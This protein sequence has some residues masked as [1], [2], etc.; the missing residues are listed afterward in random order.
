MWVTGQL[1]LLLLLLLYISL[2]RIRYLSSQQCTKKMPELKLK[3]THAHDSNFIHARTEPIN[4]GFST[5][6]SVYR[7]NVI[8]ADRLCCIDVEPGARE[9]RAMPPKPGGVGEGA[10][11]TEHP[12]EAEGTRRALGADRFTPSAERR[13]PCSSCHRRPRGN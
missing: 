2:T 13:C 12:S 3:R 6:S 5:L 4:C 1:L 8:R 9:I 10:E 7:G 11:G